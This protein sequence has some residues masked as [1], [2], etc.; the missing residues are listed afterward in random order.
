MTDQSSTTVL[1]TF[2]TVGKHPT[3]PKK[4]VIRVGIP[5]KESVLLGDKVKYIKKD[6]RLTKETKDQVVSEALELRDELGE[7]EWG[8][9]WQYF[10]RSGFVKRLTALLSGDL[11]KLEP[12]KQNVLKGDIF[13]IHNGDVIRKTTQI[14]VT[15]ETIEAT[16][17]EIRREM[18]FLKDKTRK[19]ILENLSEALAIIHDS[20]ED[21]KPVR[22]KNQIISF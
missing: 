8:G 22:K 9:D 15:D 4:Q 7:Q 21:E 6:M 3:D 12:T 16:R 11:P 17:A 14:R 2:L 13:V 18:S 1:P 20:L 5:T 10:E 19:Y